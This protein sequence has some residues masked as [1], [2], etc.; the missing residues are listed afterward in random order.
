MSTVL[1]DLGFVSTNG[2][3]FILP[4]VFHTEVHIGG[5]F[6]IKDSHSDRWVCVCV[7]VCL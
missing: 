3:V 6:F 2:K 5:L 4:W 1:N 7:S